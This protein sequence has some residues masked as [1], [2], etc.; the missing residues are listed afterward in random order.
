MRLFLFLACCDGHESTDGSDGIFT[1]PID[2]KSD[3]LI[4]ASPTHTVDQWLV[5]F[6]HPINPNSVDRTDHP[7]PNHPHPPPPPTQ[8]LKRLPDVMSLND[9]AGSLY[10]RPVQVFVAAL[11][12]VNMSVAL[13]SEYTAIA[14][15]FEFYVGGPRVLIILIVAGI[16]SVYTAAGGLLVSIWTDQAQALLSVLLILAASIYLGCEFREPLRHP[17]PEN[18]GVNYSGGWVDGWAGG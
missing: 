3:R 4:P 13:I 9:F 10:G 11:S 1:H 7:P 8:V 14:D 16:T 12:L 6:L 18:L 5:I 2:P 15:L 17:L